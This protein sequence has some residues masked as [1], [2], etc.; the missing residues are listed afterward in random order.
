MSLPHDA[1]TASFFGVEA[2]LAGIVRDVENGLMWIECCGVRF[3]RSARSRPVRRCSSACGPKT[4]CSSRRT[5]RCQVV[6]AQSARRDHRRDESARSDLP[7]RPGRR[8]R[9]VLVDRFAYRC[10]RTRPRAGK[11]VLA[12][13]KAT[14][15]RVR[16]SAT[17][18]AAVVSVPTCR[19]G[20][21]LSTPR[22]IY[23]RPRRAA[24]L[25]LLPCRCTTIEPCEYP[26]PRLRAEEQMTQQDREA[27][28]PVTAAVLAGGRSNAHGRRQD[29][30][31]RGRGALSAESSMRSRRVCARDRRDEPS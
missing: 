26:T 28:L 13:F 30:P 29:A 21:T 14:A 24:R 12:V 20:S 1:W 3:A 5:W 6:R 4:C 31:R 17:P 16:P 25:L 15:V 7:G 10:G 8:R 27:P 9:A 11:T 23:S 19:R 22:G 2:P 18:D